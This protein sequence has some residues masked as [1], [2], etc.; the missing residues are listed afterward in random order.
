MSL[1]AGAGPACVNEDG[2]AARESCTTQ[3][4][5]ERDDA[6]DPRTKDAEATRPKTNVDAR[7]IST[8]YTRQAER[9]KTKIGSNC[10]G[11]P[12]T[13]VFI[14]RHYLAK[15]GQTTVIAQCG[16]SKH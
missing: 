3:P 14:L 11:V 6:G 12:R 15:S 9:V 10:L 4:D 1:L 8:G 7:T 2:G 16:P 13:R 5:V